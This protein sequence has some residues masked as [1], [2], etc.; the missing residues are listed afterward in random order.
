MGWWT[1]HS[2]TQ[3]GLLK[4][5]AHWVWSFILSPLICCR[6]GTVQYILCVERYVIECYPFLLLRAQFERD[7]DSI[8]QPTHQQPPPG[9][10]ASVSVKAALP[11]SLTCKSSDF[12]VITMR[13]YSIERQIWNFATHEKKDLSVLVKCCGWTKRNSMS[14][15]NTIAVHMLKKAVIRCCQKLCP[16]SLIVVKMRV[17]ASVT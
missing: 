8:K 13:R 6:S 4:Y 3:A 9:L 7:W 17:N 15:R 11:V 1:D 10:K 12:L 14:C 16:E 2:V 5:K